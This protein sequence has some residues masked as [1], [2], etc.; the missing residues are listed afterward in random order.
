MREGE[1]MDQL[2]EATAKNGRL[3]EEVGLTRKD[4]A[5]SREHFQALYSGMREDLRAERPAA[6]LDAALLPAYGDV[7][8]IEE[9]S[10]LQERLSDITAENIL[11]QQ[12]LTLMQTELDG[13]QA[14]IDRMRPYA[15]SGCMVPAEPQLQPQRGL[16]QLS[17]P[18]QQVVVFG[19]LGGRVPLRVSPEGAASTS[20]LTPMSDVDGDIVMDDYINSLNADGY[21]RVDG[22]ME[23]EEPGDD[24][25]PFAKV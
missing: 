9:I 13:L 4:I 12:R 21:L 24:C 5:C 17:S 16:S 7:V 2:E 14:G 25:N 6:N 11:L 20:P 18:A 3:M 23:D 8:G 22:F 10:K 19:F 15:G 1:L